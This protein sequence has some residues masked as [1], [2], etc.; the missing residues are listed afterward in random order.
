MADEVIDLEI[1]KY[2]QDNEI[3]EEQKSFNELD[4]EAKLAR[5]D[6]L[7]QRSQLYSQIILDNIMEKSLEKKRMAKKEAKKGSETKAANDSESDE[8]VYVRRRRQKVASSHSSS[9]SD[10]DLHSD[11]DSASSVPSNSTA[12][13]PIISESPTDG[14]IERNEH[15]KKT[16]DESPVTKSSHPTKP[17]LVD[18]DESLGDDEFFSMASGSE[19]EGKSQGANKTIRDKDRVTTAQSPRNTKQDTRSGNTKKE[20][21]NQANN[22]KTNNISSGR[23]ASSNIEVTEVLLGDSS[24]DLVITGEKSRV[25][26]RDTRHSKFAARKRRPEDSLSDDDH[27]RSRI[28][29][30]TRMKHKNVSKK[31]AKTRRALVKAQAN[32]DLMQPALLTGCT[33]K[34]Y[35]LE[36]LEWLITLYENGLNGILA[37]EMGL[38]KTLQSIA[39]LCHLFEHGVKGPFLIVAPLSTV[40]NWCREFENF[41]P[42][43]K[44]MQYTGDKESRKSYIFGASSFKKHRWNVVVTSYQ[45]VVRDFRKMSRI[46][47]KYLVVDEGHR[48]KNF[49][50]LLVQFLRRLKVENRLLLTGTPLQNNLKELWSLLNF[51]LPDIFQDLELFE[52]WFDFESMGEAAA[53][54]VSSE[55]K[56][57]ISNEVQDRLVKS[58]HTIL[59]PFML[60]RMK[61]EVMKDLPPKKEYIVYTELTPLQKIFYKLIIHGDLKHTVLT[62]HLKEYLLCNHPDLFKT[63]EDLNFVDGFLD[64]NQGRLSNKR[65]R[66]AKY[67]RK[68]LMMLEQDLMKEFVVLD[69]LDDGSSSSENDADVHNV[70]ESDTTIDLA[71]N[72]EA[73]DKEFADLLADFQTNQSQQNAISNQESKM[74][75]VDVQNQPGLKI[76][77]LLN[78][79]DS[80]SERRPQSIIDGRKNSAVKLDDLE[81]QMNHIKKDSSEF[82]NKTKQEPQPNAASEEPEVIE[83]LSG[84]SDSETELRAVKDTP[85]HELQSNVILKLLP[86]FTRNLSRM[87]LLNRVMQLR[88]VCG[89]HYVYYEP[90]ADDN[91]DDAYL[92]HLI[93]R[94]SGKVQLLK[95]LLDPLLKGGHK[96]LI[97]SQ[98]TKILE[99]IG[100][101]LDEDKIKYSLLTGNIFQ[102]ERE[103]EIAL[104]NSEDE[105]S[106]KIF[107]LST[108]AG[109]LGIN[110]TTADTVI[111]FDSDWNPQMDIQ[112]MGRAHRIGQTK[113]VKVFRFVVRDSVE[114]ILLFKSFSKRALE[115][116]VIKSN[117]FGKSTVAGQLIDKNIDL[118]KITRLSNIW[119]I[120]QRLDH[121]KSSINYSTSRVLI[122]SQEPLEGVTEEEM[123]ELMDRS[124]ECYA[125]E[126]SEF[127]N[128]TTFEVSS[129]EAE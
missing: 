79:E 101:C 28:S 25:S 35:Q 44:V 104:F 37:D 13:S 52:L 1:K 108:R 4:G 89:S 72:A 98:F 117:N 22:S 107:L 46:N 114:E 116:K 80:E 69:Y 118:T 14:K 63:E 106:T 2:L 32:H 93:F 66:V 49:D 27:K 127:A 92:A 111:L 83:I 57:K 3:T 56:A 68:T 85:R 71:A 100:V 21:F 65:E 94:N 129:A 120:E 126:T 15:K 123:N 109:G 124:L 102:D 128:I 18:S 84:D 73:V 9:S 53:I 103:D 81:N 51:I 8:G 125:R 34:D 122:E 78:S 17:I 77:I 110:L 88:N 90:L 96:V 30:D 64:F 16:E 86:R 60:R 50:C 19:I 74:D 40:S 119:N 29:N 31:S 20:D 70:A 48:L 39:I 67:D 38:G 55:D 5:L 113:P 58:L 62:F 47:W 95:Q 36:G 61:K 82:N 54:D 75:I 6:N 97:F 43:L 11:S 99:L 87:R 41:A 12:K 121:A 115:Q 24:D 91:E 10:S 45:L 59:K 105:D 7:I 76:S 23:K 112:A 42:K 26:A 33:M